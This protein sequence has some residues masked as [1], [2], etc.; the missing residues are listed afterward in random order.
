MTD[1]VN[2]HVAERVK[3]FRKLRADALAV[4][5][6]LRDRMRT[7]GTANISRDEIATL[8]QPT[9]LT[10]QLAYGLDEAM[11]ALNFYAADET[12]TEV[13]EKT[14]AAFDRGRTAKVALARINPV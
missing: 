8:L 5:D 3:Y 12:W 9:Q 14:F 10:E 7:A 6:E 11:A 2:E 4:A 1:I 13:P